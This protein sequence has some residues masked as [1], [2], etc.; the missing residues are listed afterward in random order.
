MEEKTEM[1]REKK[2]FGWFN[3]EDPF[4]ILYSAF[5]FQ[6]PIAACG[7]NSLKLTREETFSGL[8]SVSISTG[9]YNT[10]WETFYFETPLVLL[11]SIAIPVYITPTLLF[12]EFFPLS[13]AYEWLF[14]FLKGRQYFIGRV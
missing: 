4:F 5:K 2:F 9:S 10:I 7:A 12:R 1:V 6:Q 11:L 13:S 3:L 14:L 8:I